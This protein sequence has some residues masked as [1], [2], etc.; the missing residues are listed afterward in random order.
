M[1]CSGWKDADVVKMITGMCEK[2]RRRAGQVDP[3]FYVVLHPLAKYPEV[4]E[5]SSPALPSSCLK[6]SDYDCFLE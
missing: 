4:K 3:N 5:L 2:R 1:L 6:S